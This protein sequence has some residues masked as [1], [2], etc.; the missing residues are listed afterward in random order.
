MTATEAILTLIGLALSAAS[1]AL[2][3]LIFRTLHP[4]RQRH[5]ISGLP[6]EAAHPRDMGWTWRALEVE[7]HDGIRVRGWY[8]ETP[9]RPRAVVIL[10]HGH[11]KDRRQMLRHAPYLLEAGYDLVLMDHRHHGDS[12]DGPF[13]LG[14][15]GRLDLAA[16]V[17]RLG[18]QPRS[19]RLPVAA[20]GV[21]LG[22]TTALAAA[23]DGVP[24]AAV[25]ADS[26]S[27]DQARTLAD[28]AWR[29]YR[30]PP[31]LTALGRRL[32]AL[33][34]GMDL[35]PVRLAGRLAG[36]PTPVLLLHGEADDKVPLEHA[37]ILAA[38]VGGPRELVTF[39]GCRHGLGH[40]E[41][42]ARYEA[43]VLDFLDR[44]LPRP[45]P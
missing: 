25:V 41:A 13:G 24:L 38:A 29:L 14:A 26:A 43:S 4:T 30:M 28:Y 7:G 33:W 8:V 11:R 6:G 35:A 27:S 12:D 5:V 42:R 2:G 39:P 9:G 17:A 18:E 44:H 34:T 40:V 3:F 37:R 21:S 23:A 32:A 16:V 45:Q 19:A 31:A 20:L 36:L 22:A 15:F 1:A 10:L